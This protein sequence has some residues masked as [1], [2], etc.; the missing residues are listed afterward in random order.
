MAKLR[1]M[2][3]SNDGFMKG[4]QNVGAKTYKRKS[5][6]W[7]YSNTLI[8]RLILKSFPNVKKNV[9]QRQ[10]AAR[11]ATVIQ[12]Y[13]RLKYTY[14]QVAE[15]M[16][17]TPLKVRCMLRSI[18]RVSKGLRANGTGTLGNKKGRPKK[19]VLQNQGTSGETI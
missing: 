18:H 5:P 1:K 17:T 14:T 15:E 8:Q 10:N 13:F 6:S 19:T 2:L 16:N 7:V 4:H 9:S 3:D 12:L 11:W